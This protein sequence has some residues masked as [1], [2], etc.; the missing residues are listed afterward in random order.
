MSTTGG[1]QQGTVLLLDTPDA[2]RKK[3]RSAVTD[4][5]REVRRGDDKPG[6]TNLIDILAVATGETP[7]E[8]EARYDGAGY[9]D[10]KARRRRGGRRAARA[11][12]A[13]AT[14]SSA[15][16]SRELL[17]LLAVGAEQG[18]RG[19]GADARGDVRAHGLRPAGVDAD[20][21]AEV[22]RRRVALDEEGL[23]MARDD[24]ETEIRREP[25]SWVTP[26]ETRRSS[27][28]RSSASSTSRLPSGHRRG[29]RARRRSSTRARRCASARTARSRATPCVTRSGA[30]RPP[31]RSGSRCSCYSCSS[32]PQAPPYWYF[33]EELPGDGPGRRR[34]DA[35]PGSRGDRGGRSRLRHRHGGE[36][37]ARGH[38]VPRRARPR[39]PRSTRARP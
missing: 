16:T 29:S 34:P 32:P 12:P 20:V 21:R 18:A 9:G 23:R 38:G 27:G 11:R 33:S 28:S 13:S 1:T 36:R 10:F 7:E 37:R 3:F 25:D 4:S 30:A 14:P 22:P 19:V 39:A 31:T 24:D 6:V 5:G 15:A 2:I 17:R 35:R 8:I 26:E